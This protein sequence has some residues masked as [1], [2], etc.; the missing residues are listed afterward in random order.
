MARAIDAKYLEGL[1]FKSS[2]QKKTE[3]GLVNIPTERQLT[4]ADVLDW[5]DNGPSL[6]IVT[7][8]GQKHV[9]SKKVEKVK[10]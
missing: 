4:P 7:A 3:D 2:K 8:D 5:K 10:E 9:V 6:T 1:L